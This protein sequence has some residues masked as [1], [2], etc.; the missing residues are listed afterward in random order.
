ML[1]E[2]QYSFFLT[3]NYLILLKTATKYKRLFTL[4]TTDEEV[5]EIE[6]TKTM[7]LLVL[8]EGW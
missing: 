8:K 1:Q 4:I 5:I 2:P 6:L 3:K 7:E